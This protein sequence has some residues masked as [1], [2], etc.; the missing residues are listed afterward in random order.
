MMGAAAAD[1][2]DRSWFTADNPRSEAVQQIIADMMTGVSADRQDRVIAEP[3]RRSA[4]YCAVAMASGGDT[5]LIAGKGHETVQEIA[6]TKH[7]FDDRI[8]ASE[9]LSSQAEQS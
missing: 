6:A 1:V 9:A 7:P 2:A 8:V 5:V 3:D 4:I